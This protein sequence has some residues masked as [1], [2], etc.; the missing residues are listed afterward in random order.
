MTT[1]ENWSLILTGIYDLLTFG[2][3][4]FVGYEAVLKKRQ[5]EIAFYMQRMP[6]DT[7]QHS[8]ERQLA[9]FVLENRGGEVKNVQ[10]K[11]EPD[12]IGWD[13]LGNNS[14]VKPRSTLEFFRQQIPFLPENERH[15][16]FWCDM[17]ANIEVLKKPFKI[18]VEFDNPIFPLL[19][20]PRK[21]FRFDFSA[22]DGTVFG[23]T[24]RYDIHNVAKEMAR[25]RKEVEETRGLITKAIDVKNNQNKN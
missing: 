14:E 16:F 8:E 25:I 5:P 15:Q 9:D 18:I 20:R 17:E 2:L 3:L 4:M 19:K 13:N 23:M 10:I 24:T 6:E 22:L 11:S 12:F 1:Y 21:E 7:K